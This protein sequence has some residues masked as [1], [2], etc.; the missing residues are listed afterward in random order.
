MNAKTKK[1]ITP[2]LHSM[3]DNC[4][5]ALAI[6]NRMSDQLKGFNDEIKHLTAADKAHGE[7]PPQ[8]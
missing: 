3:M 7:S 2:I 1:D 4:D 6:L 8:D 5:R